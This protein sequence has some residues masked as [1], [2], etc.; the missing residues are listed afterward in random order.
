MFFVST[1]Q[2]HLRDIIQVKYQ[3]LNNSKSVTQKGG[4]WLI[5]IGYSRS[6]DW[7]VLYISYCY[8]LLRSRFHRVHN[9]AQCA[10]VLGDMVKR[11]TVCKL[12]ER[13]KGGFLITTVP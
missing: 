11:P 2:Q 6:G 7:G 5:K 8:F 9:T 10:L 13:Q 3:L 12:R 4:S 1:E